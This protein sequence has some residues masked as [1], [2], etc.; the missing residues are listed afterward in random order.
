MRRFPE[1]AFEKEMQM[2][3]ALANVKAIKTADPYTGH[4][5]EGGN[6]YCRHGSYLGTWWGPDYMCGACE[7]G[8]GDY[9]YALM[10][11][12][13]AVIRHNEWRRTETWSDFGLAMKE[14]AVSPAYF[15]SLW[16]YLDF[17]TN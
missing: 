6:L 15:L 12:W 16:P 5:G 4:T 2:Q 17:S 10:C 7:D 14:K 8:M 11:G 3:S 13:Q 1:T 9:E